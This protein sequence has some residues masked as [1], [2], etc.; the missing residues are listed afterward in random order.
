MREAIEKLTPRECEVMALVAEGMANK[1]IAKALNPPMSEQTV[2]GHLKRIF[3]KLSVS[4]RT[5]AVAA[6][7]RHTWGT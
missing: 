7:L 1:E 5:A 6:Y 2:K 3:L 4:S